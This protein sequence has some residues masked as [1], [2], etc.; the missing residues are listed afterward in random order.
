[1][2]TT[3]PEISGGADSTTSVFRMADVVGAEEDEEEEEEVGTEEEEDEEDEEEDDEEDDEDG[4]EDG[5]EEEEDEDEEEDGVY[6]VMVG[7]EARTVES[8][9]ENS[10]QRH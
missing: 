5:A 1:M 2:G 10:V 9:T 7:I 6:V 3:I 8:D 4:A